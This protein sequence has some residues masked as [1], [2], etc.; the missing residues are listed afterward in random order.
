MPLRL[1][2]GETV[3]PGTIE[4]GLAHVIGKQLDLGIDCIGD[5][6]FWKARNIAYYSRHF[7]GL[8]TRP[9]KP[10][11]AGST[12]TFT[13]ERDEFAQF[14]KDSDAAGTMFFVPG[15]RPMPPERVRMIASGPVKSKGTAAIAQIGRA[16]V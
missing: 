3:A 6:E 5:G 15:E 16:H 9:L 13:R 14:Y 8:E 7:T 4:A 12:R 1:F 10:G 11:G 2:R